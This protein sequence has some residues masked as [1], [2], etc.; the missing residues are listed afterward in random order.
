MLPT[1][2]PHSP[3]AKCYQL[4]PVTEPLVLTFSDTPENRTVMQA[5]IDFLRTAYKNPEPESIERYLGVV[6]RLRQ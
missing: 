2:L 6:E 5:A 1:N 3:W 4:K